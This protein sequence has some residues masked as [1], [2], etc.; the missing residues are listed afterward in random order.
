MDRSDCCR[1]RAA[2]DARRACVFRRAQ[3]APQKIKRSE[4]LRSEILLLDLLSPFLWN[5]SS[6]LRLLFTTK[7]LYRLVRRFSL[8]LKAI[9]QSTHMEVT[10]SAYCKHELFAQRL[11]VHTTF[12]QQ[13]HVHN[14]FKQRVNVVELLQIVGLA[15][16]AAPVGVFATNKSGRGIQWHRFMSET[17]QSHAN[18][19]LAKKNR[20]SRLSFLAMLYHWVF[21]PSEMFEIFAQVAVDVLHV[22]G[23]AFITAAV[24]NQTRGRSAL[25][26]EW[27]RVRA[28]VTKKTRLA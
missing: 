15:G 26:D 23:V 24:T 10:M 8:N 5:D 18:A 21:L 25:A 20:A 12:W 3:V 17:E 28:Q 1:K 7:R 11:S 16:L 14:V 27:Q 9:F 19:L 13:W 6:M 2:C 22:R 4:M